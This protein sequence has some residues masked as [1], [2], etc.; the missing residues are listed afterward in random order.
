M[1]QQ[2][3]KERVEPTHEHTGSTGGYHFGG[4]NSNMSP[5]MTDETRTLHSVVLQDNVTLHNEVPHNT[6]MLQNEV[7]R[8]NVMLHNAVP[9]NPVTL[10]SKVLCNTVIPTI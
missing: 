10:H 7:T 8:Y 4:R 3:V 1:P 6:S 5:R 2:G 9:N